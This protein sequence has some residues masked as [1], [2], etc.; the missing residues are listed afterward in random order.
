MKR[1]RG[2]CAADTWRLVF[3]FGIA[4]HNLVVTLI[5]TYE[6]GSKSFRHDIQKPRQMENVARDIYA[7]YGELY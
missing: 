7:V 4:K 3:L 1:E 6:G 2:I 5:L